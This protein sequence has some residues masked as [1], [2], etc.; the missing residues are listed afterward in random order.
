MLV[1]IALQS[2]GSRVGGVKGFG[3]GEG[4]VGWWLK[5]GLGVGVWER[6]EWVI[7]LAAVTTFLSEAL[8]SVKTFMGS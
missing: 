6:D 5:K 8:L 3:E 1:A 7:D 4:G 2:L